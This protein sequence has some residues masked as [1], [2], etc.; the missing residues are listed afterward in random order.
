MLTRGRCAKRTSKPARVASAALVLLGL[1][2]HAVRARGDAPPAGAR[3]ERRVV[4][5]DTGRGALDAE[6]GDVLAE[7]LG[8]LHLELVREQPSNASVVA[9]VGIESSDRGAVVTVTA[10]A[11]GTALRREVERGDS[12]AVFRETLAHVILGA[13]EPLASADVGPARPLVV[14]PRATNEPVPPSR[15]ASEGRAALLVGARV[16]PRLLATDRGNVGF[17]GLA[18]V[19]LRSSLRPTVGLEAGYVLPARLSRDGV[20]AEFGLV[21]IRLEAGIEPLAKKGVA[22]DTVLVGGVDIIW[23]TPQGG[24]PLARLEPSS[25]RLQPM[26]GAAASG[27]FRLSSSA[28]FVV[29]LGVDVDAAP[30]HWVIAVGAGRDSLFETSRFRPYLALGFDWTMGG[31]ASAPA[32][33]GLP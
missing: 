17:S 26:F 31:S 22:L 2:V 28:D 33:E 24:P 32:V 6:L 14:E 3:S 13:V 27:R 23:L 25:R 4:I 9:R 11:D 18:A 20:D 8:R 10:S 30:R 15:V 16:G 19:T 29:T 5:L 1:A 7:L 21:P 12:P